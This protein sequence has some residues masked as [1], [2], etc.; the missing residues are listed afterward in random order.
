MS[1]MSYWRKRSFYFLP[2]LIIVLSTACLQLRVTR[3]NPISGLPIFLGWPQLWLTK[4]SY[5][6]LECKKIVTYAN[7][8][9]IRCTFGNQHYFHLYIEMF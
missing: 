3:T 2:P 1:I 8:G 6:I 9:H 4:N 7:I 5:Q